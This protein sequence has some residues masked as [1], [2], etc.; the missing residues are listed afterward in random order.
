MEPLKNLVRTRMREKQINHVSA[1]IN[2][3]NGLRIIHLPNQYKSSSTFLTQ[4]NNVD[5]KRTPQLAASDQGPHNF[6]ANYI[7]L[8]LTR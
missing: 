8:F 3:L 2:Y 4:E 7:N 5:P 6:L 1:T